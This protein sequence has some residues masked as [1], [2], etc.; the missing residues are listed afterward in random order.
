M[1]ERFRALAFGRN[2]V[3]NVD[4]RE[5]PLVHLRLIDPTDPAVAQDPYASINADLVREGLATVD[6]KGCRY[7]AAYPAMAKKLQ[8]SIATAKRDRAGMFEFG[9]VEEDD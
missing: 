7:L 1:I 9:D 4:H 5:G 6:R 3:A 2:L 8:E